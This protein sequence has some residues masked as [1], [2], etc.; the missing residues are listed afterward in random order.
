[1]NKHNTGKAFDEAQ[2]KGTKKHRTTSTQ[3]QSFKEL[4]ESG[5]R[6]TQALKVYAFM[7]GK[8][9]MTSR[10]LTALTGFERC[11]MTRIIN[12]LKETGKVKVKYSAKCPTTGRTVEHYAAIQL[13]EAEAVGN[14]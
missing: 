5:K 7:L 13:T 4:N 3:R 10:L 1:M 12:D 9:P 14:G 8:P 2:P 11:A 6:Q